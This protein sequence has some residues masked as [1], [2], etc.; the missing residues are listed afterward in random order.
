MA[1]LDWV[2][3][4]ADLEPAVQAFEQNYN[5]SEMA[6]EVARVKIQRGLV[7]AQVLAADAQGDRLRTTTRALVVVTA[8]L[9]IATL[10]LAVRA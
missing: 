10:I 6:R 5:S 4:A 7:A 3:W 9:V 1:D 2:S 8:L